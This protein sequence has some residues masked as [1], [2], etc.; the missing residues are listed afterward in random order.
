MA[1]S[2]IAYA[3]LLD[4]SGVVVSSSAE[5][6][7]YSDDYA[8]NLHRFKKWRSSTTTGDQWIKF[9]R[10][11]NQSFQL[12][13][14]VNPKLHSGGTL[15]FQA[16]TSDAWGAPTVS[17]VVSAPSPG[18][19][20]IW[21]HWLSA[22]QSLR[23]FRFYFTN[24]GLV[25]DYAEL[26]VAWA[27]PYFE[28]TISIIAGSAKPVRVDPSPRRVAIGG[29]RSAVSRSKYYT[30][31]GQFNVPTQAER[32]NYSNFFN[33]VGATQSFILSLDPSDS[34]LTYYG[35]FNEALSLSHLGRDIYDLPFGFTEDVA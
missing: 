8:A 21:T 15:T 23:W 14:A 35:T 27:S 32:T 4:D 16:H 12:M 2:R 19:T 24:T 7:G 13:A 9:D 10:G 17:Q 31:N 6:T 5:A 1:K 34:E 26:A 30:V 33:T 22:S 29:Q 28:P 18:L 11:S 20:N 3:N 25:S